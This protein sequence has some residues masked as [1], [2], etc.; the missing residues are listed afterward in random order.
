[1]SQIDTS[2]IAGLV[3]SVLFILLA[4]ILALVSLLPLLQMISYICAII[5]AVDTLTGNELKKSIISYLK[6]RRNE[7]NKSKSKGDKPT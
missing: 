7:N 2:S 3:S 6:K 1:M 5:L 4:K